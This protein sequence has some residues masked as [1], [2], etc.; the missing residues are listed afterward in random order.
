LLLQPVLLDQFWDLLLLSLLLE[1][2]EAGLAGTKMARRIGDIDG[3]E[4]KHIGENHNQVD[5]SDKAGKLLAEML[6]KGL[7]GYRLVTL[8]GYSLG[9]RVTFKCLEHLAISANSAGIVK[10]VVLLGNTNSIER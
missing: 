10:R 5:R 2:L 3:F 8:I 7:H 1:L 9:A 4:F 6:L